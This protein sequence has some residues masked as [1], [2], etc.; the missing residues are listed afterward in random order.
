MIQAKAQNSP[1]AKSP[2]P[3]LPGQTTASTIA[4]S[5]LKSRRRS[6]KKRREVALPPVDIHVPREEVE[7]VMESLG[8]ICWWVFMHAFSR[9][10]GTGWHAFF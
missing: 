1:L 4:T 6:E 9:C 5:T 3:I 8:A 7:N 10:S 2:K